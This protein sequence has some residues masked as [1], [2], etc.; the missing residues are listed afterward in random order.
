MCVG[1]PSV[2]ASTR[3]A[4]ATVLCLSVHGCEN[5]SGGAVELSWKLR[6][7]SSDLEDK[8]VDCDSGKAGTR[9][10]TR[11]LLSWQVDEQQGVA[12]WPC[13]DSHG[14][15]G[16]E[17]PE[18]NALLTVSPVCEEGPAAPASYIAPGAEQ[19][20]VIV[21][22]TVSLGAVELVVV[23]STCGDQQCICE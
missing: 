5:V 11:I 19:R 22:D 6:P 20:R 15:T 21:G 13:T 12:D 4:F 7:A 14:A 9:P 8:F 2:G 18:G 23:V 17:L 3:M 16:F 1:M 10:V